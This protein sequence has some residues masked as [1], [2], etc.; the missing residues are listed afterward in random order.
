MANKVR[1]EKRD[2]NT[3]NANETQ[4]ITRCH[5][6]TAVRALTLVLRAGAANI[7]MNSE[8]YWAAMA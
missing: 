4:R 6:P 2:N 5:S 1:D 8:F 7:D 3:T